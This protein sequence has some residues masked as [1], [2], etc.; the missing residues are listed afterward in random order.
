LNSALMRN[1]RAVTRSTPV[2]VVL[3]WLLMAP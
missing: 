1:S 3:T 2:L